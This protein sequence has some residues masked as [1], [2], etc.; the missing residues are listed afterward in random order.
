MLDGRPVVF[1][2]CSDRFK[3]SVARKLRDALAEV[4]VWGVIVSDEPLLSRVGWEPGD[5]VEA[6]MNAS[7][8]VVALCTAD[9]QLAD[10]T[11]QTRQN[12]I[13]EI[14]LAR[15]RPNLRDRVLVAKGQAVRLP[16]NINPTYERLDPRDLRPL[17]DVVL[18]QLREWRVI[19]ERPAQPVTQRPAPATEE[20]LAGLGLGEWEEAQR[21]AYAVASTADHAGLEGIVDALLERVRQGADAHVPGMLLQSLMELD[22]RLARPELIEELALREDIASRM[23][24]AMIL[25]SL[26][27]AAPAL[28]PLGL[29]GRLAR[30][31]DEDWYVQSPAMNAVARL[32]G[33]RAES[34]VI[35]DGLVRSEDPTDRFAVGEALLALARAKPESVPRDLVEALV[36]DDDALVAE[37]GGEVRGLLEQLPPDSYDRWRFG[38]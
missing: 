33:R 29:L 24:A 8:A 11:V 5:K 13:D 16:S 12:I 23:A 38:L 35:L 22:P 6:Y 26:A 34:R 30:P 17:I 7:D 10:G 15:E 19:G 3:E 31:A 20:L 28:V 32:M 25:E 21:R 14:R 27:K 37:K 1:L 18:R 36:G 2:S 9:D 4:G